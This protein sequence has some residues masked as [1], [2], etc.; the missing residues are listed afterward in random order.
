MLAKTA[1]V[2]E[3]PRLDHQLGS[4]VGG[5]HSLHWQRGLDVYGWR[6]LQEMTLASKRFS[7]RPRERLRRWVHHLSG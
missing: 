7:P 1:F 4:V 5:L 3:H 2:P 6:I